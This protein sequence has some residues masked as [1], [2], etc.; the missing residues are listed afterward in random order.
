MKKYCFVIGFSLSIIFFISCSKEWLD[1]KPDKNLTVPETLDDFEA[2]LDN[3]DMNSRSALTLGELATDG[4]YVLESRWATGFPDFLSNAYTW[5]NERPYVNIADWNSPYYCISTSNVVLE[6]IGKIKSTGENSERMRR[7]RG[8]ALFNRARH[9]YELAQV[10]CPPYNGLSSEL[11]LGLPLR[12]E[13]DINIRSV[14]STL[15]ATYQAIIDDLME[16][17]NLLPIR[18]IFKTR[19]SQPAVFALLSKVYLSM[20]NYEESGDFAD[21]C[22]VLYSTLLDFNK[23]NTSANFIGTFNDEVIFHSIGSPYN[24]LTSSGKIEKTLYDSYLMDDLRKKAFFRIESAGTIVFKGNYYNSTTNLFLG[25]ST[26]DLYLIRAEC[27]ARKGDV[28]KAMR[29][30]NLLL[31]NR[32]DSNTFV[33][34]VAENSNDALHKVLSER[35]K[36]FVL[37]GQRWT[38]LRRLNTDPQF[39][40]TL[41]RTIGGNTYIL[42]PNSFRYTFPIPD[43]VIQLSGIQQNI[44]WER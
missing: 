1:E 42:E 38:D 32:Y 20:G 7:I 5:S 23:I 27:F 13:S 40:E 29:D 44:G 37:R 25:L 41:T 3:L 43:D 19:A 14:R 8:G 26:S 33:P 15:K 17:K 18:P 16:A 39:A 11:D 34:I 28:E 12:F 35:K 9:L 24:M 22:L 6:G 2:M 10:F 31:L 36:E 21:S 4:H 30:L